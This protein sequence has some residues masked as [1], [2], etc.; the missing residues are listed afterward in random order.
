MFFKQAAATGWDCRRAQILVG[1]RE[2]QSDTFTTQ[3]LGRII[4]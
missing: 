4:R 2:M 3:I 1:L